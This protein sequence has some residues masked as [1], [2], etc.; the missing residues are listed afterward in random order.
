MTD[1]S[2]IRLQLSS[3][4]RVQTGYIF[5]ISPASSVLTL[6]PAPLNL[7]SSS[8]PTTSYIA[9]SIRSISSITILSLASPPTAPNKT[10]LPALDPSVSTSRIHTTIGKLQ[11]AEARRGKGV[12]REAQALF[13]A[14][15]RT[16]PVTWDGLRIVVL[17]SVLISPPYTANE[18][19]MVNKRGNAVELARVKKVVSFF[20]LFAPQGGD[21]A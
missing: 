13:D 7:S 20:F 15:H 6:T 8:L 18:C 16:L 4:S 3:P 5:S 19:Q 21:V 11:A 2:S 12:S 14:L 9:I 1:S 17:G 10:S